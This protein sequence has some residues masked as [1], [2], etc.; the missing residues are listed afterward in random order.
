MT[1]MTATGTGAGTRS[2]GGTR[3]RIVPVLRL[4]LTNKWTTIGTP[5]L[6]LLFIWAVNWVIWLL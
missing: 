1:T 2:P 4:H 5:L 6:I 3:S